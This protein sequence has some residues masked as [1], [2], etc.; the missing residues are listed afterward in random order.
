MKKI[1]WI[2]FFCVCQ[3]AVAAQN[4]GSITGTLLDTLSGQK[5][6]SATITLMKKSDSSLVSFTMTDAKG[7]F[8]LSNLPF[9]DYRLLITHVNYLNS[10]KNLVLD[11]AHKT[12]EL[13]NVIMNDKT[14][15]LDGVVVSSEAPPIT[16]KNDTLEYN[17]GS[18]KP[19]PNAAVEDLLKRLPGVKVEKDGTVKAQGQNVRKVLVDGKE[20]FGNDPKMATRNLPADAVDKVQVYDRQSDMAQLTGFDDGNSEKTINLK[21]KK[22]KK[23]GVFGRATAGAGTQERYEGKANVNSFKGARQFSALAMAN[24]TNAEGFTFMDILNFSGELR[25]MQQ[26]GGST[27]ISVSTD[28]PSSPFYSLA[29]NRSGINTSRAGGL[30]YNNIIGTKTDFSS[31][32]L[33]SRNN[34][35]S[36]SQVLRQYFLPDSTYN[37]NQQANSD[38]IANSH[39]LNLVADYRIDSFHSLKISPSFGYQQNSVLANSNYSTVQGGGQLSN[40]GFSRNISSGSG[41]NFRNDVLFRK[42]FRR[43]GRTLSM[44]LQ[45]SLNENDGEG[46]LLSVNRFYNPVGGLSRVDSLNQ[47]FTSSGDLKGYSARVAYTEPVLRRSLLE[48]SVSKSDTRNNAQKETLDFNKL[49]GAYDKINTLL[50]NNFANTYGSTGAGIRLRT[51]RNKY[52]ITVGAQW[53]Q[54]TLSGKVIAT[55][56]DSLIK[57]TFSNILPS[58]R[59][60]YKFNKYRTLSIVYRGSTNQPTIAQLQPVPDNSNPLSIREGNPDLKQE[61]I[62]SVQMNYNA[63]N[64]F[65]NRN[66]FALVNFSQTSNKIIDADEIDPFGV[67]RSRPVNVSGA[68]SLMANLEAGMPF[69]PLKANISIGSSFT[70]NRNRQ[71]INKALNTITAINLR[72][73]LRMEMNLSKKVNATVS[74]SVNLFQTLYSLP[75]ARDAKY[76]TQ[77]YGSSVDWELPKGFFF[78]TDFTYSINSQRASGFNASI[79]LWGASLSKQVL[80]YN[81]GELKISAADILN[82]NIGVSRSSNQ[83]FIE[84][85]RLRILRRFFLLS[86]TYNLNKLGPGGSGSGGNIRIITR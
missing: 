67:K 25:R 76:V 85:S 41:F 80:K 63:I 4:K 55:G 61:F 22:D 60:E 39:R 53:Q 11:E 38:N 72:P 8:T 65:K 14:R 56:K 3:L 34:P 1:Y 37:Y 70:Y 81:R 47:N 28:D 13:G 12:I 78:S 51:A 45:T 27:N 46:N 57:K 16:M 59:L 18:F 21:L 33:Y 40:E 69:H 58:A 15:M 20:F 31:N 75:S 9:G 24:N 17:A 52:N 71:L 10:Q 32:Y 50:T 35:F 64:P 23:K 49:T 54:A 83:N 79:P 44:S 42:K 73:E 68:T 19:R 86:F 7:N 26:G 6:G 43:R 66:L 2:L 36:E 5:V 84:D 48:L 30:N 82:K 62:H 77:E 29:A 74:A